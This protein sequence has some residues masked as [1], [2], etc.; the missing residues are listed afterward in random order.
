MQDFI[1]TQRVGLMKDFIGTLILYFF[2]YAI[3]IAHLTYVR[4][5]CIMGSSGHLI[6][7]LRGS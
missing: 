5:V 7:Y 6:V 1:G 4:I 3:P 2:K